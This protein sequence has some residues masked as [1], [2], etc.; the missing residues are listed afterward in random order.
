MFAAERQAFGFPTKWDFELEQVLWPIVA[1]YERDKITG[2]TNGLEGFHAYAVKSHLRSGHSLK[3]APVF[4]HTANPEEL[5]R[6]LMNAKCGLDILG[7]KESN[8]T[9][10]LVVDLHRYPE[11][12]FCVWVLLAVES[13]LPF[14]PQGDRTPR[15]QCRRG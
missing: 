1:S 3:A 7:V 11:G 5:F 8:A 10:G 2:R 9:F 14:I 6:A 15:T 12:V 13:L 4:A